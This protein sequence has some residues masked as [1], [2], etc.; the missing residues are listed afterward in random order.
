MRV[1]LTYK[2]ASYQKIDKYD[3]DHVTAF[4]ISAFKWLTLNDDDYDKKFI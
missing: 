2:L 4:N 1:S 3:Q